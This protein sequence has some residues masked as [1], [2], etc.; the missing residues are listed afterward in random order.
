[1]RAVAAELVLD[2]RLAV[3]GALE[4]FRSHTGPQRR[5]AVPAARR[6]SGPDGRQRRR[7]VDARE[8]HRRQFPPDAR[9]H[10]HQGQGD[11]VPW[12]ARRPAAR[13]RDRLPGSRALRQSHRGGQ[14]LSRPRADQ[15]GR[16][17]PLHGLR[18]D[19]QASGRAVQGAEVGDQTQGQGEVDVGR[20]A[21][22]GR[23]RADAAER[24]RHRA[25]GRADRG[26]LGPPGRGGAQS[27]SRAETGTASPSS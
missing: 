20:P 19:E 16:P 6:G 25:D 26:D 18:R 17:F 9:Q 21:P 23:H 3:G 24:R 12:P 8:D 27:H 7:Q 11:R 1:M 22:G 5:L 14:R 10:L 2:D 15:I 13:D 4:A